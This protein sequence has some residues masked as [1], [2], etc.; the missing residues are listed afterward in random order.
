MI[1]PM[2]DEHFDWN[3]HD[4]VS[5]DE[6]I[7]PNWENSVP[8]FWRDSFSVKKEQTPEH[9]SNIKRQWKC[10]GAENVILNLS[11]DRLILDHNF[12]RSNKVIDQCNAKENQLKTLKMW[13]R[14]FQLD[15][16]LRWNIFYSQCSKKS[17]KWIFHQNWICEVLF[18]PEKRTHC[19]S[20]WRKRSVESRLSGK[21]WLNVL[22]IPFLRT[23]LWRLFVFCSH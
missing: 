22:W 3:K 12:I 19:R 5:V 20:R 17:N 2:K 11:Q 8:L 9:D 23:A 6:M 10:K 15:F 14:K 1:M 18:L 21:P 7:Q 16:E 13:R 4:D